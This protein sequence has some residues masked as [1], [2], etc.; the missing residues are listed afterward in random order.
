MTQ[1]I[2]HSRHFYS[3]TQF[4]L[5]SPHLNIIGK[6]IFQSTN[7]YGFSHTHPSSNNNLFLLGNIFGSG[8]P[9]LKAALNCI[10]V[11]NP[12]LLL[13]NFFPNKARALILFKLAKDLIEANLSVSIITTSIFFEFAKKLMS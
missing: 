9:T 10:L 13:R 12:Y 3:F 5:H 2:L 1:F 4:I 7:F 11:S 6:F 8:Y